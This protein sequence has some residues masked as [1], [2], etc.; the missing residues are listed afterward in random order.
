MGKRPGNLFSRQRQALKEHNIVEVA[1]DN[2]RLNNNLKKSSRMKNSSGD[3]LRKMKKRGVIRQMLE[4]FP[5]PNQQQNGNNYQINLQTH[6]NHRN[7]VVVEDH[8]NV[9]EQE[10]ENNDVNDENDG[11]E[12]YESRKLL[13]RQMQGMIAKEVLKDRKGTVGSE[14]DSWSDLEENFARAYEPIPLNIRMETW[15]QMSK[16]DILKTISSKDMREQFEGMSRDEILYEIEKMQQSAKHLRERFGIDHLLQHNH[17]P[18]THHQL[19]RARQ[20]G[21]DV[22]LESIVTPN[23]V[24][25]VVPYCHFFSFTFRIPIWLTLAICRHLANLT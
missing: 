13:I 1:G 7:A 4:K 22:D 21:R 6:A 25:T 23:E 14:Y 20:K 11:E 17:P 2:D 3:S 18:L 15:R 10:V 9:Y 19:E 16:K 8:A 24:I 12:I 5:K